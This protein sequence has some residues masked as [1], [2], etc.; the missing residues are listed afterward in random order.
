MYT[1]LE[2]K[3]IHD[4]SIKVIVDQLRVPHFVVEIG[5]RGRWCLIGWSG[6]TELV[7]SS[8]GLRGDKN[9]IGYH[10]HTCTRAKIC[11]ENNFENNYDVLTCNL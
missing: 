6:P 3:V 11:P 4:G 9:A 5:K 1:T 10:F 8:K 7:Q 2:S